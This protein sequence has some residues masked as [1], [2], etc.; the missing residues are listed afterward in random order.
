MNQNPITTHSELIQTHDQFH[1]LFSN[2]NI[3]DTVPDLS[4][5]ICYPPTTPHFIFLR[6][7]D[8]YQTRFPAISYS[9]QAQLHL[10]RLLQNNNLLRRD[11][12]VRRLI[13]SIRYSQ[14]FSLT[15]AI[16]HILYTFE[17]TNLLSTEPSETESLASPERSISPITP[18]AFTFS[19]TFDNLLFNQEDLHLDQ[20]FQETNMVKTTDEVYDLVNKKIN[21]IIIRVPPYSGDG[22]QDPFDWIKDFTKAIQVNN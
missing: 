20:L 8:W 6:F 22:T 12:I 7:W 1:Q 13:F 5:S 17:T 9:N 18:T 19:N 21:N 4:C 10:D 2:Q 3:R 11:Q 14:N 15:S 16:I